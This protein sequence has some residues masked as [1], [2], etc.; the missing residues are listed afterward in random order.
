MSNLK[1]SI[2]VKKQAEVVHVLNL[3]VSLHVKNRP[4]VQ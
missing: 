3:V 2:K 4:L 1:P